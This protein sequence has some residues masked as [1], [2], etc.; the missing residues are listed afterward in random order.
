MRWYLC[1]LGLVVLMPATGVA[2]DRIQPNVMLAQANT[3][4]E[5]KE[6]LV[7]FEWDKANL[8]PEG[9]QVVATAAQEYVRTGQARIVATGYTDTSGSA[10]YNLGLSERRAE[11]VKA[12]LVSLGVPA[13]NIETLG[14]G[15]N[16]LLVPTGDG[17][18]EA[19]NRRVQ[20]EVPVAAPA[21]PPVAAA[22]PPP[23]PPP[24]A[25]K[26]WAVG[27]GGWYGYNLRETDSNS[28]KTSNLLGVNLNVDYMATPNVPISVNIAGF[29]TLD[30]AQDNGWGG[31][32]TL[33]AAYQFNEAGTWHPYIG[34]YGGYIL[35]KGVQ[36]SWLV[37]PEAGV[38]FDL[39]DGFYMYAK[40]GYDYT[41][42]NAVDEGIIN[43]GLGGGIRF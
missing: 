14:E 28:D 43:G 3:A 27:L 25:P 15:Q 42:R 9:R 22:A 8:T 35:G 17:V 33:G 5:M 24:P 20:I 7:F 32:S 2:S 29:N 18:R 21:P 38:K 4:T 13:V 30:T 40:A 39:T 16:N 12:E 6:F 34:A 10:T 1:A 23:P 19:Q 31:R 26:K 36:D 11:A 37:G 41:F